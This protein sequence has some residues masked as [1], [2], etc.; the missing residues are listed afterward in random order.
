MSEVPLY[1]AHKK[2]TPPPLR[3]TIGPTVG[4]Y[5]GAAPYERV[6]PVLGWRVTAKGRGLDEDA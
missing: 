1:L 5:G 4:S 3:G 6:T 2:E